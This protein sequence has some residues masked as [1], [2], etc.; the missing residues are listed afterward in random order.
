MPAALPY[1][2]LYELTY[3]KY[4]SQCLQVIADMGVADHIGNQP[5]S[6][7]DLA[8]SCRADPDGLDRALRL[9]A[10]HGVFA[11]Q[12]GGWAHT[13]SSRLLRSDHPMSMRAAILMHGLPHIVASLGAL[14]YSVQTGGPASATLDPG[15]LWGYLRKHPDE[16][17]V[18]NQ[19]MRA[20]ANALIASVLDAYDFTP[21]G[22]IADI[23][24]GLGHLLR[25]V[26][27]AAP[28]AQGILFDQPSV[29]ATVE[30]DHPRL[31]VWP[32]DFFSDPLPTADAYLLMHVIHDWADPE[33]VAIL[34]AVRKGARTGSTVLLIES[35][36]SEEGAD[37]VTLALDINMLV[38]T[39]GR[40]RTLSQLGGLLE[41]AGFR[42]R[43]VIDTTGPA[44]IIEAGA[45]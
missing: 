11:E 28:A 16:A 40:E 21:F 15:G 45:V 10:A 39:G 24:G 6:I 38:A 33:A 27:D 42:T 29:I 36:I 30:V 41:R 7:A 9:L 3:A 43:R 17:A 13:P 12:D 26:L 32:G 25:A 37:L 18:V 14:E 4:S 35:V 44:S 23:A 1:E 8:S 34:G 22:T 2:P 31:T 20:R 5:V 19:A